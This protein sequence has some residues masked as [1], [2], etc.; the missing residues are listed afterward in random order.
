[1]ID[2]RF[3]VELELA[4]RAHHHR[5]CAQRFRFA[6]ILNAGTETVGRRAND[7]LCAAGCLRHDG[8]DDDGTLAFGQARGLTGDA[9]RRHAVHS[10][11]DDE[12]DD[13]FQTFAVYFALRKRRG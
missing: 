8:F 13:A 4:R 12:I 6:G 3:R 9:Q 10:C 11:P 5:R 2:D 1:V 7:D